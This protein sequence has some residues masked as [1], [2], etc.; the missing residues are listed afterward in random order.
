M[1]PFSTDLDKNTLYKISTGMAAPSHVADFLLNIHQLGEKKIKAMID[2]CCTDGEKFQNEKI[3]KTDILNFASAE[4][5]IK[6][7]LGGKTKEITLQ[8]D[9]FARMLC[10]AL[11]EKN[12]H[13]QGI[14]E[15]PCLDFYFY[16][17]FYL[18]KC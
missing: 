1:N 18:V 16:T 8:R 9:L 6:L 4:K 15:L 10:I 13:A 11:D 7:S 12:R 17:Q 14:I 5:K 3:K 2:A